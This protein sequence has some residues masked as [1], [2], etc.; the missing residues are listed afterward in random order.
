MDISSTRPDG[1]E[2]IKEALKAGSETD[3]ESSRIIISYTGAPRYRI[4]I[5][6]PDYKT[7]E[8]ILKISSSAIIDKITELGGKGVF[9][10]HIESSK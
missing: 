9:Y 1:V 7:A 10:R 6:A 4:K 8:S 2:V 5:I 3:E